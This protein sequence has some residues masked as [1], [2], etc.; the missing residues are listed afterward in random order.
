MNE[1]SLEWMPESLAPANQVKEQ[2][3]K[4]MEYKVTFAQFANGSCLM[5]KPVADLDAVIRGSM[6]EAKYLPDFKVYLMEEGD[7][8][9]SF[10]SALMVYVGKTEFGNRE[11][12]LRERVKDLMYPSESLATRSEMSDLEVL[13]GLYARAK[14]QRDVRL[15]EPYV[16]VNSTL[17]SSHSVDAARARDCGSI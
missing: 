12:E 2:V 4:Y 15:D 17:S 5:L 10:A 13:V 11:A 3:S 8:L 9:V 14:L 16:I 1:I 6:N 7:F